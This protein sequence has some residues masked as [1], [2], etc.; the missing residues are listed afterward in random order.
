MKELTEDD[1]KIMTA[2]GIKM[3]N[4]VRDRHKLQQAKEKI[5]QKAK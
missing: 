1:K 5:Q 4:A 3:Y 2:K